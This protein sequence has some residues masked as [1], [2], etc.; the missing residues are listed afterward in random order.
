[1]DLDV[2]AISSLYSQLAGVLA[3][4]ALAALFFIFSQLQAT[5]GTPNGNLRKTLRL[6]TVTFVLLVLSSL[7]YALLSGD[8]GNGA[9]AAAVQLSA[10][11]GFSCAAVLLVQSILSVLDSIAGP[12]TGATPGSTH[13]YSDTVALLR[14]IACHG[15]PV[16]LATSLVGGAQDFVKTQSD[17]PGSNKPVVAALIAV[18]VVFVLPFVFYY[19]KRYPVATAS[20]PSTEEKRAESIIATVAVVLSFFSTIGVFA[21]SSLMTSCDSVGSWFVYTSVVVPALFFLGVSAHSIRSR[22]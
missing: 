5:T 15:L 14:A 8:Q 22:H 16:L 19:L 1:M 18:A 9:R 2:T 20:G 13:D 6:V 7:S 11:V 12:A 4:F 21:L 10:A 17:T 3:G